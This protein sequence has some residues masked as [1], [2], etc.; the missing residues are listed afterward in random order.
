MGA[1]L[2]I[3]APN[4]ADHTER[5]SQSGGT[6]INL[7]GRSAFQLGAK[8]DSFALMALMRAGRPANERPDDG[9]RQLIYAQSR[10]FAVI[11][12]HSWQPH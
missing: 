11:T 1:P 8:R 3:R 6:S 12:G 4:Q 9:G 7:P 2:G 10:C 5:I